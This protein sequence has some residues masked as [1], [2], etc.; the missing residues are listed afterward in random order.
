MHTNKLKEALLA[1]KPQIGVQISHIRSIEI[2]RILGAAGFHWAFIDGEHGVYHAESIYDLNKVCALC[3]VTPVVR[4]ASLQYDLIARTLDT[5][6]QG[7]IFPRVESVELLE[8]AV[9][10]TKFPPLGVRGFGLGAVHMDYQRMTIPATME[11]VH[12]EAL[13][14]LQIESVKA[15]EMRDELLSVKGV[16]AVLVGPADLSISMGIPGEFTNP[17]LVDTVEKIRDACLKHNVIPGIHNRGADM[18]KF[19]IDRGMKLVGCGNEA[20][21]LFEK[22]SENAK[23]LLG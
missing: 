1:G 8:Q 4:V 21:M 12:R 14:V 19:W 18:A 15:F 13:N 5:G 7:I 6:A 10:W 11:L 17:K 3:G 2:P 16:D 22:A 23:A 20:V 9:A